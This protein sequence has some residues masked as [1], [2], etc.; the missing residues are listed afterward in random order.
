MFAQTQYCIHDKTFYER[1]STGNDRQFRM[2]VWNWL[3]PRKGLPHF[4]Q[5]GV[6]FRVHVSHPRQHNTHSPMNLFHKSQ[7]SWAAYES[8]K[9]LPMFWAAR[10]LI[11]IPLHHSSA[12][13]I[14]NLILKGGKG[15]KAISG[16]VGVTKM[17]EV[18][19]YW[20]SCCNT[21]SDRSSYRSVMWRLSGT[22]LTLTKLLS[23]C[24]LIKTW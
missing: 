22:Y 16:L 20:K 4:G 3:H 5:H 18:L 15:E 8:S 21:S 9:V 19:R 10:P 1:T 11:L 6:C 17:W 2:M 23:L 24:Q 14:L 7:C 12:E 13:L